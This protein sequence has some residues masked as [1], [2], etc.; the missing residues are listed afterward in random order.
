MVSPSPD[1]T[2]SVDVSFRTAR[3]RPACQLSPLLGM[4]ALCDWLSGGREQM[5]RKEDQSETY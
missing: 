2:Q 5:T 3:F 4:M 1:P